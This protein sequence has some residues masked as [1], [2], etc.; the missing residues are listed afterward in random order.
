MVL[1]SDSRPFP[2]DRPGTVGGH[3]RQRIYGKLDCRAAKRAIQRG[4][5]YVKHRVFFLDE[6]TA[7]AAGYRPCGTCMPEQYQAWKASRAR[8]NTF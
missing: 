1:G 6:T 7:R 5:V 2:S 8:I 4:G 3:R